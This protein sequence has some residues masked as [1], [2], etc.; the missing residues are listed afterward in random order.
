MQSLPRELVSEIFVACQSWRNP[1]HGPSPLHPPLLFC[2]ICSSWRTIAINTPQ[3]WANLTILL[4]SN[5]SNWKHARI[6][7]LWSLRQGAVLATITFCQHPRASSPMINPDSSHDEFVSSKRLFTHPLVTS[8]RAIFFHRAKFADV[9]LLLDILSYTP[10]PHLEDMVITGCFENG[11]AHHD[12]S[13]GSLQPYKLK[14]LFFAF[15]RGARIISMLPED[16]FWFS[17]DWARLTHLSANLPSALATWR[18][19]LHKCTSLTHFLIKFDS[20]FHEIFSSDSERCKSDIIHRE[21]V[22]EIILDVSFP[23]ITPI[24]DGFIFPSATKLRISLGGAVNGENPDLLSLSRVLSSTPNL[25]E[26]HTQFCFPTGQHPKLP[27]FLR[28]HRYWEFGSTFSHP[29]HVEPVPFLSSLL[30]E[31]KVLVFD[32][33]NAK[34]QAESCIQDL[35]S[36]LQSEWLQKGWTTTPE[37]GRFIQ[38]FVDFG[39]HRVTSSLDAF[40]NKIDANFRYPVFPFRPMCN[41][42]TVAWWRWEEPDPENA[43]THPRGWI[44]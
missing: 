35:I 42:V 43:W 26:L 9:R 39:G 16:R 33:I 14:R 37:T 36:I 27:Q 4:C 28:G 18:L 7:E 11:E 5:W 41:S 38:F 17:F 2:Q 20:G 31:L 15:N 24:F 21:M 23:N 40:N 19:L 1:E 12:K 32:Y 30:P 29:E 8:A 22:Q 10:F 44:L 6:L 3:L 34:G 13:R 25:Q